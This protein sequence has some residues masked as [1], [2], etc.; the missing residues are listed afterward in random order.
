MA[1]T[2]WFKITL[3]ALCSLAICA[4]AAFAYVIWTIGD[5]SWKLS[6]MDD[7]HLAARDEFKASLST[8]TCL[9]RE[10]IIEE[11]NR[12]DWPVRDQSDFFWCHAPTGLSN[13]LRVQVEPS[14]LMSTEDENAAFYGFDSD[15]CSV[16]WSYASGEGTTCPN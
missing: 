5:S 2:R 1:T 9:T 3:I 14:L 4:A 12:R 15:G 10:T 16:D 11:A 8:Q 13:W 6:G 7:A